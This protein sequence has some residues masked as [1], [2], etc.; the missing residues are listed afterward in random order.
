MNQFFITT[1]SL[2]VAQGLIIYRKESHSRP[3]FRRHIGYSCPIGEAKTAE[4]RA[5][6]FNKSPHNTLLSQHLCH[7][8]HKVCSRCTLNQLAMEFES[9]HFGNEHIQR[10]SQHAGL[11]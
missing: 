11:G 7:G 5:K 2:K 10:L 8:K 1:R 9:N 4:T 3:I 6:E